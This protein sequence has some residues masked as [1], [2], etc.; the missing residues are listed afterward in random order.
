MKRILFLVGAA[1]I[2]LSGCSKKETARTESADS[3]SIIV[4]SF[5]DELGE[6]SENYYKPAYPGVEVEYTMIP[7]GQFPNK[8]EPVLASG[9]GAP[10]IFA[11]EAD[12]VR[13]YVESGLLL[14]L[15]DIYEANESKLLAYPVEVGSYNGKVYGMSWQAVPG[16]MF[17]RRSLAKKYLGTDDPKVVQTY[18]TNINKFEETAKLLKDSSGGSCV[19]V[20]ALGDIIKVFVGLRKSPWVVNDKLVIDPIMD[21]FLDL[22]KVLHDNRWEGRVGP[23]SEGW[24]AGMG[25]ELKDEAGRPGEVFAYFLPTGGLH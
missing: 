15:S 23:W 7:W 14:D 3:G 16:A 18:F 5:T 6:M 24:F 11:L 1:L 10:D 13:K 22:C 17:Y 21:Q 20:S 8:L 25:G 4:W 12:V 9:Q 19:V 2:L